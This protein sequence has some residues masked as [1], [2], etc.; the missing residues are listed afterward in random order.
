MKLTM[1]LTQ[2]HFRTMKVKYNASHSFTDKEGIKHSMLSQIYAIGIYVIYD[3][4]P[5][6]QGSTTP[7]SIRKIQTKLR[8]AEG[9]GEVS[10]LE[11][12]LEI[13]V[14]NDGGQWKEVKAPLCDPIEIK[15]G[16]SYPCPRK[17]RG[18]NYTFHVSKVENETVDF[19]VSPLCT[20]LDSYKIADNLY[21]SPLTN[22]R[23]TIM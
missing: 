2:Y 4:N 9:N 21:R 20:L 16:E 3:N 14:T 22:F 13:T 7:Q 1:F 18:T 23:T 6:L 12:G 15:A 17:V 8:K 11:F 5:A 19:S 10:N